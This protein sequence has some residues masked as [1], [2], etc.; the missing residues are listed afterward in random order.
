MIK[1]L[2]EAGADMHVTNYLGVNLLHLA[3]YKDNS[4]M[5][6]M[7]IESN[8]PIANLTNDG[9]SALYIATK[10]NNTEIIKEILNAIMKMDLREN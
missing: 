7:L 8:Y 10:L 3:V 4:R 1:I 9:M 5:V 2:A 6:E